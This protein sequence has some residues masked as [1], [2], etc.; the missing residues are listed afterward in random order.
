MPAY[1]CIA[2]S[3]DDTTHRYWKLDTIEGT[4][5]IGI[6]EEYGDNNDIFELHADLDPFYQVKKGYTPTASGPNDAKVIYYSNYHAAKKKECSCGGGK[7]IIFESKCG[8]WEHIE[9]VWDQLNDSVYGTPV[10]FYK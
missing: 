6:D 5:I 3:V 9:H 4:N 2:W 10:R 1:N 7:W 8:D